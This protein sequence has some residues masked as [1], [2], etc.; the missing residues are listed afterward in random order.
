MKQSTNKP[1]P[2]SLPPKF[3]GITADARTLNV[4]RDH[5]YKVLD[6]KRTSARLLKRYR[7]LQAKAA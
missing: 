6:G 2:R 1:H 4:S 3:P 5:L 7:A